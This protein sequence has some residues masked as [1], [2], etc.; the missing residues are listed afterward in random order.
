[1]Q[2]NVKRSLQHT[3]YVHTHQ[4]VGTTIRIVLRMSERNILREIQ[5]SRIAAQLKLP[6]HI[7]ILCP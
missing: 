3:D 4:Y 6:I 2:I 1:M 7:L 5:F